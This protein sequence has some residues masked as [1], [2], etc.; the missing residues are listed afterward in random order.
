[1]SVGGYLR[2]DI[3]IVEQNEFPR[4]GMLVWGDIFAEQTEI[5]IAVAFGNISEHLIVGPIL[6]DH[7]NDMFNWRGIANAHRY[8]GLFARGARGFQ[9]LIC[10]GRI[11]IDST[12]QARKPGLR[13]EIDERNSP[14][15][16]APDI[17]SVFISRLGG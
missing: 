9:Q 12:V 16:H 2:V 15:Q 7:I 4:Q 6:F 5:G 17:L 10:I 13:W 14:F 11:S 8:G 3:E 1:M